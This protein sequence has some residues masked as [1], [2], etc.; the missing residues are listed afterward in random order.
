MNSFTGFAYTEAVGSPAFRVES[1][2]VV[3]AGEI[4]RGKEV[5]IIICQRECSNVEQGVAYGSCASSSEGH[6]WVG[7]GDRLEE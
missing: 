3:D 2:H 4:F 5:D 6:C 7:C 1:A